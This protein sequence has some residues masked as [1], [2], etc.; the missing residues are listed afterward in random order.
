[1]KPLLYW[2]IQIRVDWT[3]FFIHKTAQRWF[4]I[5]HLCVGSKNHATLVFLSISISD[6]HRATSL[7]EDP[8]QRHLHIFLHIVLCC[9]MPPT[10]ECCNMILREAAYGIRTILCDEFVPPLSISR[11]TRCVKNP[12]HFCEGQ[13]NEATSEL[14]D[15]GQSEVRFPGQSEVHLILHTK[16]VECHPL[17]QSL[18]HDVT[19]SCI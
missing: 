2:K 15:P 11:K 6:W 9:A 5:T 13:K 14:K 10:T 16:T 8:S 18:S 4:N 19:T 7:L 1:M 3:C 12:T 17:Y